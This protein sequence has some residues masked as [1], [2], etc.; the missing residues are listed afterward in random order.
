MGDDWMAITIRAMY[1]Y[2]GFSGRLEFLPSLDFPSVS[3]VFS[4]SVPSGVEEVDEVLIPVEL[5]DTDSDC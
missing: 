5:P 2:G 3:A 4:V 1:E